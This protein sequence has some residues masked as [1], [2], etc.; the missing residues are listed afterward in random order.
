MAQPQHEIPHVIQLA[1]TGGHPRAQWLRRRDPRLRIV[2]ALLVALVVVSLQQLPVLVLCLV[3]ALSLALAVGLNPGFLAK[4]LLL[5][6]GFMLV[7]LVF[8]PFS[9][10]GQAIFNLGPFTAT[11]EGLSRAVQMFLK[12][13]SLVVTFMALVGTLDPEVLG[14]ALARLR[15]PDKLVHLFLFT[16]RY[17]GVLLGEYRRLRLAMRARAFVPGSNRHTWRS[18]GWLIGMLLMRSLARSQRVLAA[19]KCRGFHGRFYLFDTH[20]WTTADTFVLLAVVLLLGGI[21]LLEQYLWPMH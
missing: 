4:R 10:P 18:L 1:L 8:I 21:L 19:M 9:V 7:L 16:V 20:R 12:A 15:L 13:N 14:H 5:L 6:E 3:L 11:L 17:I 2:G